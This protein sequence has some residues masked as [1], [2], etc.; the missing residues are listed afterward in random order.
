MRKP[1]DAPRTP[2]SAYPSRLRSYAL[3][4][5]FLILALTSGAIA[6]RYAAW[7]LA[8][9][10]GVATVESSAIRESA[11]GYRI[12]EITFRRDGH[13]LRCTIDADAVESIAIG[14][15]VP[16][17][18]D[19]GI[20]KV[21]ACMRHA[22]HDARKL[23]MTFGGLGALVLMIAVLSLVRARERR[24]ILIDGDVAFGTITSVTRSGAYVVIALALDEPVRA[25]RTCRYPVRFLE[26]LGG[27]LPTT[28]AR[29]SVVYSRRRPTSFLLWDFETPSG[30]R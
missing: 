11:R 28:G 29:A 23:V 8:S 22:R 16:Y 2:P 24:R 3:G 1:P 9:P 26:R 17:W 15:E 14:K 4:A 6:L 25:T 7:S 21:E 30:S 12:G 27:V 19:G 20:A 5:I 10:A 13:L 18:F